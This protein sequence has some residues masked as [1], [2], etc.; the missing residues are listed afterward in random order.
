MDWLKM[1]GTTERPMQDDWL[2][3]GNRTKEFFT[4]R[5]RMSMRPGDR[6]A[7]YATGL[8]SV[9]ALGTVTSFA[10]QRPDENREGFEWRVDVNLDDASREFIHE[11]VPLEV[12]SVDGRDLRGSIKQQSHIKLTP[13]E[14]GAIEKAL[15]R[16]EQ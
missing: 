12:V 15:E 3:E 10:Y 14:F 13:A 1:L 8:G 6:V 4:S 11:G 2:H 7:Y 9:F 5:K 16:R